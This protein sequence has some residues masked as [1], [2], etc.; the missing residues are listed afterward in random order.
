MLEQWNIG[1][2]GSGV[3]QCWINGPVTGGSDDKIKMA[4][5]LLKNQYSI[6]PIF[7]YSMCE[8]ETPISKKILNYQ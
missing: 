6:I 2:M 5:I 3:M 7:H 1:I 8:A 4:N